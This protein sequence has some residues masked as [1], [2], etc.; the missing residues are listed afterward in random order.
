MA[1]KPVVHNA[2][3]KYTTQNWG[4]DDTIHVTAIKA[5]V[6][7]ARENAKKN[8]RES[9]I[10]RKKLETAQVLNTPRS[11]INEDTMLKKHEIER[12]KKKMK[13]DETIDDLDQERDEL[14]DEIYRLRLTLAEAWKITLATDAE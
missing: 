4:Y 3:E 10:E 2:R 11:K 8:E 7:N 6:H 1:T 14:Y 12:L 9:T 13:Q 5:V